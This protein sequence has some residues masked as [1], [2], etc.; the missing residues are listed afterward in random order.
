MILRVQSEKNNLCLTEHTMNITKMCVVTAGQPVIISLNPSDPGVFFGKNAPESL[1]G[2]IPF[3]L[4]DDGW[5]AFQLCYSLLAVS[6]VSLNSKHYHPPG[7]GFKNCQIP[8]PRQIIFDQIPGGWA[9]LG[10]L[11]L[12]NFTLF[13]YFQDLSHQFTH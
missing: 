1:C 5:V 6:N 2:C 13:H 9:S 11:I 12:I 8:A 7:Q 10:P 4:D 3:L